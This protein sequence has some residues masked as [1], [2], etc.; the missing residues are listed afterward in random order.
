MAKRNGDYNKAAEIEYGKIPELEEKLKQLNEQWER[1]Q[2]EGTLLKNS[3]DEEA[4]AKIVSRWTQIPVTK[5]LQS[6]KEKILHVEEVLAEDVVGQEQAI[7]AV[8][9]AIKR[10]KAGLSEPNRPIGSFLFLGPTGVGKTQTAK[11]L[12]K[13]LFDTEK[14]LIRIDMSEYMEKHAVS[15]LVGAPPGYVGYE[16][17]GQLTEAVRRKPYSVILFDEIEKAHPDVFN[18]LLQVLDDGR[19]TDNKG[20]TVDFRNT[21]IILTS[22]IASDKIME[23]KDPEDRE[24]AV[25]D[26]LKMYFKPEFLN[27]LDDIIIFNPLDQA[28]ITKIVDILFR[29]IQEKLKER[30]IKVTL[31]DAAK[32]LIAAA[33]FDP[34]Y[35]ARPL[36][37]ALYE[38]VEDRLAEL[39]LEDRVKEGDSV[40]FDAQND[41]IVVR[42][43]P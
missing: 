40:V 18:V 25:K 24:K 35:G 12:A 34:V 4:I 42:I 28:A 16:E 39:I 11:T 20:V 2:E 9:R 27:R 30:D 10:N 29:A 43:N 8:A 19:L 36:K 3:V 26:E 6:E 14:S 15:R 31:T 5:M 33:G 13:F 37:R 21:I 22:N 7:K 41:E 23:F 1:M 38:L 17:G 32:A